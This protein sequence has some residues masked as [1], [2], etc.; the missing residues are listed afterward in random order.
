[1]DDVPATSLACKHATRQRTTKP[2]R[3]PSGR[4]SVTVG[5]DKS[6]GRTVFTGGTISNQVFPEPPPRLRSETLRRSLPVSG[7]PIA[8]AGGWFTCTR[9]FSLLVLN[10]CL[11]GTVTEENDCISTSKCIRLM[12][13]QKNNDGILIGYVSEPCRCVFSSSFN[14]SFFG[15]ASFFHLFFILNMIRCKMN[16]QFDSTCLSV[17]VLTITYSSTIVNMILSVCS[18]SLSV[19]LRFHNS[20]RYKQI[21]LTLGSCVVGH[22]ACL[23]PHPPP[24]HL[25]CSVYNYRRTRLKIPC[26][27]LV[28]RSAACPHLQRHKNT[29]R[30]C[31]YVSREC[32]W[33]FQL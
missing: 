6:A 29:S 25:N 5:K 28:L 20:N 17:S 32:T 33:E 11:S 18:I 13:F 22:L 15:L 14:V 30:L 16:F 7:T 19:F 23:V 3:A 24:Q 21:F 12:G 26:S 2:S 4:P 31:L 27:R 1:M 9:H 10:K 8:P